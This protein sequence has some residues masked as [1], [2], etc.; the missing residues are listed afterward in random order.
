MIPL[1][2]ETKPNGVPLLSNRDIE[3]DAVAIL[4]DFSPSLLATP[5]A[6]DIERFVESYLGLSIDFNWLTS[7][8]SILG[9]MVFNDSII[10]VYDP[11]TKQAEDFPFEANT[12]IIDNS[13]VD[14]EVLL[15]STMAHECGHAIY[16]PK[17]YHRKAALQSAACTNADINLK[18]KSNRLTTDHDWM[19][20]HARYFSAAILMPYPAVRIASREYCDHLDAW[21]KKEPKLHNH[22]MAHQVASVFKVSVAAAKIRLRQLRLDMPVQSKPT[23]AVFPH[24]R[25]TMT[26]ASMTD[27]DLARIIEA[28]DDRLFE[29][30]YG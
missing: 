20:H 14:I 29:Q 25:N 24:D 28:R 5:G 3:L 16:H 30:Y 15:R 2:F 6:V 1:Y 8:R 22:L 7:N 21:Y 9:R 26:L 13:V 27:L 11:I 10:P 23:T 19:E 18:N 4:K 17:Y 12:M